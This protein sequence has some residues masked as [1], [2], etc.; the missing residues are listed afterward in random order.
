MA[1]PPIFVAASA[2]PHEGNVR[3]NLAAPP[4]SWG[5]GF[6]YSVSPDVADELADQLRA[7]AKIARIETKAKASKDEQSASNK[8]AG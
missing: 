1:T 2:V 5:N 7:A 8:N 3:V 4:V 6:I